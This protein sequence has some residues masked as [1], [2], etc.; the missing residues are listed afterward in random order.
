MDAGSS[1]TPSSSPRRLRCLGPYYGTVSGGPQQD[2][3]FFLS[4]P[5]L[6]WF[7]P[8]K[9]TMVWSFRAENGCN[10]PESTPYWLK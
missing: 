7:P 6:L 5:E 2:C 3:I 4:I 8:V 1:G 9:N 10:A